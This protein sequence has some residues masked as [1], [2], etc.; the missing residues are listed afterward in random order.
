MLLLS[1]DDV[2]FAPELSEW[3]KTAGINGKF[4]GTV[5]NFKVD[6]LFYAH[7]P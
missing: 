7:R 2:A 4:H 6:D 1:S 3:N 5:D